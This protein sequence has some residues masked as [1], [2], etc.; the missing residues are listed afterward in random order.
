VT[1]RA[2]LKNPWVALP[3]RAP[4]W[5]P[6]DR[7][8]IEAFN[9]SV[10]ATYR[11]AKGLLPEP[12]LGPRTAPLVLLMLSPGLV[13]ADYGLHRSSFR[14]HLRENLGN[15]PATHAHLGLS[16]EFARRRP[17]WANRLAAVLARGHSREELAAR[18]LSVEFHG[19][20]ARSFRPIGVTLPSQRYGFQIVED[21]IDRGAT[22]ITF[23]GLDLW[24]IAV[25]RLHRY[26]LLVKGSNPRAPYVSPGNL[27]RRG[28]AKVLRAL[29]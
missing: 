10:A 16:P 23:R 26:E 1:P 28:F 4:Y 24:E 7:P 21:A 22:I 14:T 25:P 12:F 20:H 15:D 9:R 27:G 8:H 29:E 19:Y 17:W 5:L 13:P 6:Q 2:R 18:V 11:L 3:K